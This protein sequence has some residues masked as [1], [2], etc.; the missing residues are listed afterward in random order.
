MRSSA[1]LTY[2]VTASND[3]RS[4]MRENKN[5]AAGNLY[6]RDSATTASCYETNDPGISFRNT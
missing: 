6:Y 1:G 2:S 3:T 4:K 5:S